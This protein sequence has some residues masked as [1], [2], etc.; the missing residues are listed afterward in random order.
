M[1]YQ[2][3]DSDRMQYM[4]IDCERLV[5]KPP[6][7]KIT[8]GQ[9]PFREFKNGK[10][11]A[12]ISAERRQPATVIVSSIDGKLVVEE[13]VPPDINPMGIEPDEFK[14]AA[15]EVAEKALKTPA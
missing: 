2:M 7:F 15:I 1:E 5:G 10:S 9:S 14:A 8:I 11:F 6:R 13:Y 4:D 12:K 3:K